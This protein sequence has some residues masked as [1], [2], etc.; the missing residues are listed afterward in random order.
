VFTN[1]TNAFYAQDHLDLASN[2]K[3]LVGGRY[4]IYRRNSH[5]DDL[6]SGSPVEG[7]VAHRETSAFTGRAGLVYQPTP[8]MDLYGS[9]ANSFTPLTQAQPDGST[10]EPETGQQWEVGQR[11]RMVNDRVQLTADVFRIVRQ[12]VAFRRPGNVFVQAGEMESRGF[13][14]DVET[15]LMAQWRVNASYGF[16][17]AQFN[18]FEQSVGNNLRGNTPV[19]APRHT[20]NVWTGYEWAG[21]FGASVGGRYFGQLFADNDNLFVVNGYGTMSLGVHYGHGPFEYALNVNNLTNTKY[22]VPHQDYLQ[23]Y[24]GEPTNVLGTIRIRLK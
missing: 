24:P 11:L 10:L 16:T 12:N 22:F 20:F 7:P 5:A 14:M 2:V 18:D 9:F 3:L 19:Y 21:G 17:D 4:D 15:S 8:K 23:V 1:Y 13:E 6:T